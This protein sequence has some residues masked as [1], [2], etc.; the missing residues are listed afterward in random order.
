MNKS[1]L[2][3]A[4]LTEALVV[5]LNMNKQKA[6]ELVSLFFEELVAALIR[7]ESVHLSGLGNF[8]LK[9]KK[10]RMGRNPKTKEMHEI[11]ARR[12]VTFRAGKKLKAFLSERT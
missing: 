4:E 1:T 12:V 9:N 2:T 5:Q 6:A 11:K 3:K 7:G 8:I 10:S